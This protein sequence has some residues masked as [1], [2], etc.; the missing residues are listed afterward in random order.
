VTEGEY[1]ERIAD[2]ERYVNRT[3]FVCEPDC[4]HDFFYHAQALMDHLTLL[5]EAEFYAVNGH[6]MKLPDCPCDL[7]PR[8]LDESMRFEKR[9]SNNDASG[10]C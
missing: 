8:F 10:T 4:P 1:R 5:V 6:D 9:W 7:L 2:V 3:S